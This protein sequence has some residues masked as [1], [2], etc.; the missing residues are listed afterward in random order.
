MLPKQRQALELFLKGYSMRRISE[1]LD[2]TLTTIHTWRHQPTFRESLNEALE[3]VDFNNG[4]DIRGL[5]RR[6]YEELEGLLQDPNPMVRLGA[7]RLSLDSYWRMIAVN[8]DKAA[9]NAL[10][11]RLEQLQVLASQQMDAMAGEATLALP[12]QPIIEAE[13]SEVAPS[14]ALDQPVKRKRGRPRKG[15]QPATGCLDSSPAQPESP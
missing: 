14:V 6:S 5:V 3:S 2:V 8:E 13:V 4:V 11:T 9:I 10:E 7:A 15:S 1:L 12:H